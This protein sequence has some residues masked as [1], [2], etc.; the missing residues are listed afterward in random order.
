MHDLF[1]SATPLIG[2]VHLP[3]LPGS[4]GYGGSRGDLRAAALADA[5]ALTDNGFDAL[6]VE[7]YGD[8]PFYPDAVPKHVVA[9]LTATVRELSLAVDCPFGVNV[10][11]NDAQGALAVAAAT[12]GSFVRVNV[13]TGASVTDQGVLEGSAHET[14]RVRECLD[15]D[16][17]VL[18]DIDVKHATTLGER[19]V[20]AV[21]TETIDRGLADGL[22][23]SGPATGESADDKQLRAVL[24][25]RDDAT[26]DV[27]VLLGSGV[28]AEN[29]GNLLERA[30]GAIV[31]TA[32]KRDGETSNPVDPERVQRLV[33]ASERP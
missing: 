15:A 13:H 7:N 12:G 24:D 28:T 21:A 17:A 25:A 8:A 4:P 27:P 5:L 3:P 2:M 20:R 26:R 33:A 18:A 6:L 23:V 29:V 10:L 30:D 11:R 1:D 14:L 16:V 19:D 9:E 31:G 32:V 22:V